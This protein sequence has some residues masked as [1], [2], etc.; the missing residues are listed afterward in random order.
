MAHSGPTTPAAPTAAVQ[1]RPITDVAAELGLSEE[2]LER[3]GTYK[4]KVHLDVPAIRT[5]RL[6]LV[7][8]IGPTKAGEGKTTVS[9][10]LADGLSRLGVRAALGLREPS[11]GPVFGIKGG[12]TG[13]GN[14]QVEPAADINLHFTGDLHAISSAHNLLAALVDNELHFGGET[15]LTPETTTWARV[16][17]MNDRALR[18]IVVSDG[19]RIERSTRFDIT[20]A[21]EIMA[22]MALATDVN[23]LRTR[24][25]RIVV[26]SRADG[27][28]VTADDL[29]ATD[30]MLALLQDALM[31][32]LVQTREGTPT[33]VHTGPF[34]N[35]AHGSSSVVSTRTAMKLADIVVSEAGF[36]FDLGGEKF[37]N[38]KMRQSGEWPHLVVMVVTVR[39]LQSH[40]EGNLRA[41]LEH[42]AR[43]LDNVRTFGLESVV[44]INVFPTDTPEEL[45]ELE[46]WLTS[47]GVPSAQVTSFVDGGAGGE[48]LAQVVMEHLS[49]QDVPPLPQFTYADTDA[50]DEKIRRI[51]TTLY[52]AESVTFS[53]DARSQLEH[54]TAAGYRDL[55]V[56]IAKT[57]LSFSADPKGGGLAEGF[58]LHIQ[59]VRLSAGAGFVVAL[60]GNIVTMPALPRNPAAVR[61]RVNEAGAV[62]GLMQGE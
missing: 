60:A 61:V 31:P 3:Y 58:P 39:A 43:Q 2:H 24:L 46:D 9:V 7:S 40:G 52:G 11:L 10:G 8:A 35:I 48:D 59:E 36:G 34:G 16:M 62:T 18:N 20:A 56:C 12:G 32:N 27:T 45:T 14:A 55:P 1:L 30:A 25:A 5:G 6:V 19:K 49:A 26:G 51:A 42:L 15:G 21:S 23:D 41:G 33:F 54:I 37:L 17:D 28:V 4:A 29:G 53:D 22:I 50:L 13:G 38:I 57:H 44:A 47:K